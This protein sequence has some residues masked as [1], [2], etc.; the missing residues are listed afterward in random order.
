MAT[1]KT[2]KRDF[3]KEILTTALTGLTAY[4]STVKIT[5]EYKLEPHPSVFITI[6]DETIE[7]E[8]SD[9][10]G[11]TRSRSGVCDFM[12]DFNAPAQK[13]KI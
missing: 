2:N 9:E 12:I 5:D 13:N 7:P 8:S 6:L 4:D 3:F 1:T 11:L 10:Y